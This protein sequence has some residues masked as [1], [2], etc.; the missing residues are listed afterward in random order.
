MGKCGY[1]DSTII[2]GGMH[3]NG[4]TYCNSNCANQAMLLSYSQQIPPATVQQ[5]L[6]EVWKGTCPKCGGNGPVDVHRVYQVW[7]ALVLTRWSTS[8]RICCRSCA[9]KGQLG[10]LAFSLVCGWWGFPWG[11][12]LTPVQVTRNIIGICSGPT[13]AQPS[14][15]LRKFVLAHLGGQ[16]LTASRQKPPPIPPPLAN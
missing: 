16:M 1:C 5:Q 3:R 10:G 6:E 15:E 12:I 7:S 13:P 4:E 14:P 8:P 11:L 2:M 9:T